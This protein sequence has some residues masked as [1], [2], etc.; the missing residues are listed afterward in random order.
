MELQNIPSETEA[1]LTNKLKLLCDFLKVL[2]TNS[3]G[4]G[5]IIY[6]VEDLGY[7]S[8]ENFRYT[9]KGPE[10]DSNS[11]IRVKKKNWLW[12]I[13]RLNEI[14]KKQDIFIETSLILKNKYKLEKPDT[15]LQSFCNAFFDVCL[16]EEVSFP[17]DQIEQVIERFLRDLKKGNYNAR[18]IA[19]IQ[20]VILESSHIQ[21]DDIA[22]IRQSTKADLEVPKSGDLFGYGNLFG[23][24]AILEIRI[25]P[26][27]DIGSELSALLT[28]YIKLLKLFGL[29]SIKY[30]SYEL[31]S[32]MIIGNKI[33]GGMSTND[34]MPE[35]KS[36]FLTKEMQPAL[37][38]FIA[39]FKNHK[40]DHVCSKKEDHISIAFQR[41]NESLLEI[42]SM[43][44][45]VANAVMGIEALISKSKD[46]LSFRMQTRISK[47]MVCFG[48]NGLEV[49]G[50]I[51]T[52]YDVRSKFAHGEMYNVADKNKI[53][54]HY[55]GMDVF[56]LKIINYL[57]VMLIMYYIGKV[58]KG[59]LIRLIDDAL[60]DDNCFQELKELLINIK[61]Y[62]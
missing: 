62:I 29:G 61:E 4:P 47:L 58:E 22:S 19:S 45:R 15:A 3:T 13:N 43:E 18:V 32:D 56:M 48:Y 46:E 26:K 33:G 1:L 12:G 30:L 51:K 41:Y 38:K 27:D 24:Q 31:S 35:W 11:L 49:R 25:H 52:A 53:V 44:R 42:V 57:R 16:K 54:A 23:Y 59:K 37:I 17:S 55:G 9:E 14:A 50:D 39:K 20:G 7:W 60:I 21:L 34:D 6:H 36:F 40:N 28:Y 8:H 10:S 5:K 2:T